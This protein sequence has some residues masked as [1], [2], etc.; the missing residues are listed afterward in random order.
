MVLEGAESG[1]WSGVEVQDPKIHLHKEERPAGKVG[2]G[3]GQEHTNK[4]GA[5][6]E[7]ET[8]RRK[9]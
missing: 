5:A 8:S 3:I 9:A 7:R 4:F 6:A 2:T 1:K